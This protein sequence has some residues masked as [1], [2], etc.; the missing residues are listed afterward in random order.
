MRRSRGR[1]KL[2]VPVLA[3]ANFNHKL[4]LV[5]NRN[6]TC[7]LDFRPEQ[8]AAETGRPGYRAAR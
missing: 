1:E 6:E 4:H 7:A 5:A 3:F 8:A 2:W